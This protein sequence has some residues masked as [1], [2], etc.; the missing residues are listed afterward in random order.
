M[1]HDRSGAIAGE[2][3]D[4][5]CE[6]RTFMVRA[7][8]DLLGCSNLTEHSDFFARGGDSLLMARLVRRIGKEFGITVSVRDMSRRNLG[9]QIAL[10]HQGCARAGRGRTSPAVTAGDVRRSLAREWGDLLGCS[11]LTERSDFFARGGDS[12]LMARLV[13]RIGKEFGI[14]VSVRDMLAA[15][16]FGEQA[17]LVDGLL[18]GVQRPA[19][20]L[21]RR[22][23]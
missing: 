6:V 10:V 8:G 5:A 15:P 14:T 1:T 12:L 20:T 18:G 22:A 19:R 3:V 23:A 7:W 11:N 4:Q 13:R 9:D 21:P 16:T 2:P 17:L